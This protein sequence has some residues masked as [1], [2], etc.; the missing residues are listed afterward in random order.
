MA[1]I[2]RAAKASTG[3]GNWGA[4]AI[5]PEA[6]LDADFNQIV[7]EINGSL[8]NV[9]IKAGAAIETSKIDGYSDTPTEQDTET[10]PGDCT[11]RLPAATLQKEIENLRY[12]ISRLSGYVNA[13]REA[14]SGLV[15]VPWL[16]PPFLGENLVRN[17]S[18]G[19]TDDG[20]A[21]TGVD[22]LPHGWTVVGTVTKV[23]SDA[24]TADG[25]GL[26]WIVTA[27]G[28]GDGVSYT[29]SELRAS[30]KY[31]IV[32]RGAI[33]S[34][35]ATI[36]TT[37]ADASSQYRNVSKAVSGATLA[38]Y[39]FVVKTDSTPTDI[40]LKVLSPT[41]GYV[42]EFQHVGVYEL[43]AEPLGQAAMHALR[44]ERDSAVS[45]TA[46]A[47]ATTIVTMEVYVPP[48]HVVKLTAAGNW[49]ASGGSPSNVTMK[50][51]DDGGSD[52][53]W[54]TAA[55]LVTAGQIYTFSTTE[56]DFSPV[57]SANNTYTLVGTAGTNNAAVSVVTMTAEV[58]PL[59]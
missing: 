52:L 47:G 27:T 40:V 22:D 3:T 48:G 9:N 31:L 51:T 37:G 13:E 33:S 19:T 14:G 35:D 36:S 12:C 26:V 46:G 59:R 15:G 10:S 32:V 25:M 55:T 17:A 2:T 20:S 57:A 38:N 24:I 39:A 7:S 49:A 23:L 43:S 29:L 21:I 16:E 45:L 41:S 58:I 18:F 6:E 53:G 30:T 28:A 44:V 56:V 1:T 50:I 8:E 34:G 5:L 4:G 54:T 42:V 11:T